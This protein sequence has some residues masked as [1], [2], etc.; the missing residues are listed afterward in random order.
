MDQKYRDT[1]H[2]DQNA[3]TE[4]GVPDPH[5]PGCRPPRAQ[6]LVN[7][8]DAYYE[9]LGMGAYFPSVFGGPV[10]SRQ[11]NQDRTAQPL[12][13]DQAGPDQCGCGCP[14]EPGE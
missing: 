13:P 5:Q 8:A 11:G 9:G 14:N 7:E 12:G 6:E 2:E 4:V 1:H 3:V 10:P